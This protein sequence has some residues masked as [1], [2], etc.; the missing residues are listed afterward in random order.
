MM[1][2]L[3][4]E[5]CIINV[6]LLHIGPFKEEMSLVIYCLF[7]YL[8]R[9]CLHGLAQIYP[10]FAKGHSGT[11]LTPGS[12]HYD[13]VFILRGLVS[14]IGQFL[15]PASVLALAYGEV[16]A[17]SGQKRKESCSGDIRLVSI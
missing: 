1:I 9:P 5:K 10:T 6:Q 7:L 17:V 11:S 4:K 8:F 2:T 16:L 15:D 12:F 14:E 3:R 13:V